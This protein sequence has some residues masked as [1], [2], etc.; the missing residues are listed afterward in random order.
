MISEPASSWRGWG[1]MYGLSIVEG[2]WP[3]SY[4]IMVEEK[5]LREMLWSAQLTF[6]VMLRSPCHLSRSAHHKRLCGRWI[7]PGYWLWRELTPH[8][9]RNSDCN[10]REEALL[11]FLG[12]TNLGIFNVGC[13]LTFRN[14]LREEVLDISLASGR[15]GTRIRS[16]RVSEEVSMSEVHHINFELTG[17]KAGSR[18]WRSPMKTDGDGLWDQALRWLLARGHCEILQKQLQ[19][20]KLVRKLWQD[21]VVSKALCS[22]KRGQK[23]L[24]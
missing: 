7:G 21:L 1:L 5:V 9:K 2:T 15:V 3:Q 22:A 23:T 6:W 19:S 12:T 13:K 11:K 18:L 17:V 10:N 20:Q 8:G 4:F 24:Q 16:W 14:S